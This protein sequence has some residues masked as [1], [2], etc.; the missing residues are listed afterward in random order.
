MRTLT[1]LLS[2]VASMPLF[3]QVYTPPTQPTQPQT[4]QTPTDTGPAQQKNNPSSPFGE[5]I[6]MLDPSAETIKVG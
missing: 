5:E 6:P 3:S 1:T 2:L 4:Q